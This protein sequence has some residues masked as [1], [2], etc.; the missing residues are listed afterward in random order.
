M[1]NLEFDHAD[2]FDDIAAIQ[3]QF[4]HLVRTVPGNGLIISPSATP[5]V[6]EVIAQGCWT[7]LQSFGH[8]GDWQA[9]LLQ[10][11]GS[12]FEVYFASQPAGIVDWPMTG[13]HSV[14]NA[15]ATLAAARHVGVTPAVGVE[16]LSSFKGVKRRMEKLA[17][18]AGVTIFD[19]FAHHPT[20]G[21]GS[22]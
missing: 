1:N 9:K 3:R 11:D 5:L 22:S 6:D 8:Q 16:A 15:L 2:I 10:E 17:E 21:R 7:T 13:R 19:D 14:N 4:H 18:V 12:R 20:A